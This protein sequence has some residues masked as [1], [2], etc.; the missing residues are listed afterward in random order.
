M[1]GRKCLV[2]QV[3]N[4]EYFFHNY[5]YFQYFKLVIAS[6]IPASK[7]KVKWKETRQGLNEI[8]LYISLIIEVQNL[9]K[10][11][12]TNTQIVIIIVVCLPGVFNAFCFWHFGVLKQ[13][14]L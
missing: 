10:M 3:I 5:E 1:L 2:H 11:T 9:Y 7:M 13:K 8:K 12:S 4:L 6:A 14:N